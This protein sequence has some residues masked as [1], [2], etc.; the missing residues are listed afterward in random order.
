MA[1][2]ET[3]VHVRVGVVAEPCKRWPLVTG[4]RSRI[5]SPIASDLGI[6]SPKTSSSLFCLSVKRG[7]MAVSVGVRGGEQDGCVIDGFQRKVIE[8]GDLVRYRRSYRWINIHM[9]SKDG[10]GDA[11][12]DAG[13]RCQG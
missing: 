11:D 5:D 2:V 10:D 8:A 12:A 13:H 4:R 7:G 9:A 3:S 1:K 6:S